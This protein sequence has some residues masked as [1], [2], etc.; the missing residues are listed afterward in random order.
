MPSVKK[1]FSRIFLSKGDSGPTNQKDQVPGKRDSI[2]RRLFRSENETRAETKKETSELGRR[3]SD[4]THTDLDDSND[5]K[6]TRLSLD[7]TFLQR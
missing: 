4:F 1:L 6:R 3:H 5:T 7:E 2:L